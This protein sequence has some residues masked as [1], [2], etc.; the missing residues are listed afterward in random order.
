VDFRYPDL[1]WRDGH[2][3]LGAWFDTVSTRPSMQATPLG[4]YDGPLQP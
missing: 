4:P 3:A 1:D 2:P